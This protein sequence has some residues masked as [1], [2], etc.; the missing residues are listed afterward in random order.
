MS[1]ERPHDPEYERAKE[2]LERTMR[3]LT[4]CAEDPEAG[5]RSDDPR[6]LVADLKALAVEPEASEEAKPV[7]EPR[8]LQIRHRRSA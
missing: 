5:P 8:T 1:P 3:Y 2:V 7:A 4:K 6:K